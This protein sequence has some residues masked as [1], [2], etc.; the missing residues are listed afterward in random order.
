MLSECLPLR[1][2]YAL[3]RFSVLAG[4]R[5]AV[6]YW[7]THARHGRGAPVLSASSCVPCLLLSSFLG[8]PFVQ[9]YDL[10][11]VRLPRALEVPSLLHLKV[12]CLLL[13]PVFLFPLVM[14]SV[15]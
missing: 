7:I 15:F 5:P 9:N 13:A 1:V 2:S 11:L 4:L 8:H 10:S 12:W 14:R 6:P 3:Q